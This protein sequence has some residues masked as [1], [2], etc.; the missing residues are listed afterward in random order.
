LY[1][2]TANHYRYNG[3]ACEKI[4]DINEVHIHTPNMTGTNAMS[5]NPF[6]CFT[7]CRYRKP[8]MKKYNGYSRAYIHEEHKVYTET[9]IHY[10]KNIY[11]RSSMHEQHKAFIESPTHD[12]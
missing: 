3:Y 4:H 12:S 10:A 11:A 7:M 2:E 9:Y 6:S 8:L 1:N 5:R